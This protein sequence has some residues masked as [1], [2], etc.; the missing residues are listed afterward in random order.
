MWYLKNDHLSFQILIPEIWESCSV[1]RKKI[2]FEDVTNNLDLGRLFQR[3]W[4]GPQSNHKCQQREAEGGFTD[5]RGGDLKSSRNRFA[6][7]GCEDWGDATL[8]QT[9]PGT[10]R[11]SNQG[12]SPAEN[13]WKKHG[14]AGP[15]ISQFR[16]PEL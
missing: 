15:L 2:T 12:L 3:K 8:S 6:D 7:A 9:M 13:L 11:G 4:T 14:P 1:R 10:R 5:R 16:P